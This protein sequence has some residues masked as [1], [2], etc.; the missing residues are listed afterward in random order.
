MSGVY[1]GK[2]DLVMSGHKPS[3]VTNIYVF[4]CFC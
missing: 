2:F 1:A 4:L 3:I